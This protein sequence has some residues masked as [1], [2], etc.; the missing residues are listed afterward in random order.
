MR[1]DMRK[2]DELQK[3]DRIKKIEKRAG[4]EAREPLPCK[5]DS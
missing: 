1:N 2:K 3:K 5:E 4:E